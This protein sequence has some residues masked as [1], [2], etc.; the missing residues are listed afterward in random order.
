MGRSYLFSIDDFLFQ[1]PVSYYS[2]AGKWDLSP[3]YQTYDRLYLTRPVEAACLRCHASGVQPVAGTLNG[4]AAVPF[5]EGGIGCER[6]H[7]PG[8]E[9]IAR[10]KIGVLGGGHSIVNPR[11][12]SS[13]RR[14][15]VCAQCHLTGAARIVKA[16][17][18]A[19][20]FQPGGLLSDYESVFVWSD[21]AGEMKVTSHFE[22]LAQ[23]L[24]KVKSGDRMFCG[25]C[26][27]THATPTEG[28]KASYFRGKCLACHAA[29]NPC[30]A[31]PA[32]RA[33]N[34]D[35]C[36]D[37]H[38]PKNPVA[39]V[40]HATYT[41]H[42]IPRSAIAPARKPSSSDRVLIPFGNRAASDRDLGLAYAR[43]LEDGRNAVYEARAFELLK[44]AIAQQPND[45]PAMVQLANLYGY[46]N[47]E[48][49]IALYEQAVRADPS[50]VVAAN[51]LGAIL[52]SFGR[53]AEAIR[54]WSTVLERGPGFEAA[55][56]N[57]AVAQFR[58]GDA[59]A[60]R[61]TL[62]KGLDLNPGAREMRALLNQLRRAR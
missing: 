61:E 51:N 29:A 18:D 62:I 17:R 13:E 45:V 9:H 47:D 24:C 10:M 55:R 1:A 59:T 54:L 5:L 33:R 38:M 15:S 14:D 48:R 44:T 46:R 16:G 2:S 21:P 49:A 35:Q 43:L 41:D 8:E 11:K 60:A 30:I 26:H 3:G 58:A 32:V 23:S 20:D 25:S 28:E 27:E 6:C 34:G 19:G 56:M 57:L 22:K 53:S 52:M 12:L 4:Y 7:G 36:I 50:Q 39:D 37:C 31:A 42:A 40:A